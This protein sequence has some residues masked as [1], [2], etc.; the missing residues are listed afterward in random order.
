MEDI[1]TVFKETSQE[2]AM[3]QAEIAMQIAKEKAQ[4]CTETQVFSLCSCFVFGSC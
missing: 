2:A 4:V 3:A 1:N